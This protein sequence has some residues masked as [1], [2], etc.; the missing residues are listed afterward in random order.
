MTLK[1]SFLEI[2]FG[3]SGLEIGCSCRL[4]A[5]ACKDTDLIKASRSLPPVLNSSYMFCFALALCSES[6]D[7]LRMVGRVM[8][9]EPTATKSTVPHMLQRSVFHFCATLH[10]CF[11]L[12]YTCACA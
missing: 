3:V 2:C 4:C 5:S 10:S 1:E 8:E 11:V 6:A 7:E 12:I 9:R